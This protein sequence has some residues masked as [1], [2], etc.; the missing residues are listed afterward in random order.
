MADLQSIP[1]DTVWINRSKGQFRLVT[2]QVNQGKG[3][4]R[5]S[6]YNVPNPNTA[7]S[8]Q[9]INKKK[10]ADKNKPLDEKSIYSLE[11]ELKD[12]LK[13]TINNDKVVYKAATSYANG[14]L[15]DHYYIFDDADNKFKE[16]DSNG[17]PISGAKSLT[18]S[19]LKKA[20]ERAK[21]NLNFKANEIRGKIDAEQ[22]DDDIKQYSI[23]TIDDIETTLKAVDKYNVVSFLEDYYETTGYKGRH[24]SIENG[25]LMRTDRK[26]DD[27]NISMESRKNVVK[28]LLDAANELGLSDCSEYKQIS[29]IYDRYNSETGRYKDR[30]NMRGS[31]KAKKNSFWR[32][33]GNAVG[34]AAAGALVGAGIG[35]CA[36]GIGAI[37]GC[38]IGAIYGA[39]AGLAGNATILIAEVGPYSPTDSEKLDRAMYALHKK[40]T[41][42]L[43][44]QESATSYVLPNY[45]DKYQTNPSQNSSVILQQNQSPRR[46]GVYEA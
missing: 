24:G 44:Q 30:D 13:K 9:E 34:G 7:P 15:V 27:T 1:R 46:M 22:L 40:I 3:A 43:N 38:I 33:V 39:A 17:N 2:R 45:M 19:E 42:R 18:P 31:N 25:L 16:V 21:S 26:I 12:I 14:Q 32:V 37:P 5:D 35:A 36:G 28:S 10:K 41:E 29:K 20:V 11:E 4:S 23:E 6:I 8:Q